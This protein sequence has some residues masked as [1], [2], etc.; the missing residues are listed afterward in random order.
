MFGRVQ[1]EIGSVVD[2]EANKLPDLENTADSVLDVCKVMFVCDSK[3][4]TIIDCLF[5]SAKYCPPSV[6]ILAYNGV[7][8]MVA[9]G[10]SEAAVLGFSLGVF[11]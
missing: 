10:A 9:I 7:K 8:F 2:A 3:S 6:D 5:I 1:R 4:V 11:V